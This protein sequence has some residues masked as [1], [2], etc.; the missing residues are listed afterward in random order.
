[1]SVSGTAGSWVAE[2]GSA[3]P[4]LELL[5]ESSP[6]SLGAGAVGKGCSS[7]ADFGVLLVGLG[8]SGGGGVDLLGAPGNGNCSA[9]DGAF[10]PAGG[11]QGLVAWF[12]VWVW[13]G[14]GHG[15]GG[16]FWVGVVWARQAVEKKNAAS[17][18][19][20]LASMAIYS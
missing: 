19:R 20:D 4:E 6:G 18:T 10:A 9:A 13:L 17:M 2:S 12:W 8:E 1:M 5:L 11:V 16:G 7:A 15:G 14:S 3:P